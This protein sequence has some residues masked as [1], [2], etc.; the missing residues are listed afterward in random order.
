MSQIFPSPDLSS[1]SLSPDALSKK[2]FFPFSHLIAAFSVFSKFSTT[3]E[4]FYLQKFSRRRHEKKLGR[5]HRENYFEV[6]IYILES[7]QEHQR[8]DSNRA[9]DDEIMRDSEDN[10]TNCRVMMPVL[11]SVEEE[12]F[13]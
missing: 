2:S 3:S 7:V 4:S 11:S 13:K 8:N 6:V 9:N 1:S 10:E 5:R 12:N